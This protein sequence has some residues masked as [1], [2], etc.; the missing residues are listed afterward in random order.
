MV[1]SRW[2]KKRKFRNKSNILD[3]KRTK[4]TDWMENYRTNG[5]KLYKKHIFDSY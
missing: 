5:Y 1:L 3:V 2:N 4:Q